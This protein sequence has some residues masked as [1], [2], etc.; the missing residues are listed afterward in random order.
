[1]VTPLKVMQKDLTSDHILT[2]GNL[3]CS[4]YSAASDEVT[5]Q[6]YFES[7]K[8]HQEYQLMLLYLGNLFVIYD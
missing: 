5:A 6:M 2:T 4:I 3:S 7:L 8:L 1:M